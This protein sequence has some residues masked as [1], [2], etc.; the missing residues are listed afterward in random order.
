MLKEKEND[1]TKW[2]FHDRIK[3]KIKSKDSVRNLIWISKDNINLC[4][5][6]VTSDLDEW[7]KRESNIIFIEID[8]PINGH[9]GLIAKKDDC[10]IILHEIIRFISEYDIQVS[11]SSDKFTDGEWYA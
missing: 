1:S 8:K 11:S 7:L 3:F 5:S 10:L 2:Y 9:R 4:F 6:L